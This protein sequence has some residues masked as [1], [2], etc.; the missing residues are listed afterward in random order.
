MSA[1][2]IPIRRRQESDEIASGI[3]RLFR[4]LGPYERNQ[5]TAAQID[6]IRDLM[7]VIGI[8]AACERVGVSEAC[9]LKVTSGFGHRLRPETAA[10]VRKFLNGSR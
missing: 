7:D 8:P 3:A 1:K 4:S 10:K 2:P 5:I 6:R 9:L